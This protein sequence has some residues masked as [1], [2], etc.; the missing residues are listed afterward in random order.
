ME[1]VP[2]VPWQWVG[3]CWSCEATRLAGRCLGC[4]AWG[5]DTGSAHKQK[6]LLPM[7]K[8]KNSSMSWISHFHLK[9]DGREKS[10]SWSSCKQEGGKRVSE[11]GTFCRDHSKPYGFCT[12][13]SLGNSVRQE[14]YLKWGVTEEHQVILGNTLA[15]LVCSAGIP[16]LGGPPETPG[17]FLNSGLAFC[18]RHRKWNAACMD[19][20]YI[21]K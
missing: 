7:G 4:R 1:D 5:R 3:W 18:G 12:A 14:K 6:S 19:G 15:G 9:G 20:K 10:V 13:L 8:K 21:H 11:E 16:M 17:N 2:P